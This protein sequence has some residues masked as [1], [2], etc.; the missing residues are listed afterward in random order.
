MP[1]HGIPVSRPFCLG[2][3]DPGFPDPRLLAPVC[4]PSVCAGPISVLP[5]PRF[6]PHLPSDPGVPR[7][8]VFVSGSWVGPGAALFYVPVPD[9]YKDRHHRHHQCCLVVWRRACADT[10][11]LAT[12][13]QMLGFGCRLAEQSFLN[14]NTSIT[15][16]SICR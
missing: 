8:D 9:R 14:G 11:R 2:H 7:A 10:G 6:V 1:D 13:E 16:D 4:S 15:L 5:R 3:P 12:L